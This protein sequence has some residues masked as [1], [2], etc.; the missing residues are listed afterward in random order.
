[1]K[2][3]VF[4]LAV[5][6]A[7]GFLVFH[8]NDPAVSETARPVQTAKPAE[9][10]DPVFEVK[11][12]AKAAV[13]DI[14]KLVA[15]E[16]KKIDAESAAAAPVPEPATESQPVVRDVAERPVHRTPHFDP[17]K[18]KANRTATFQPVKAKPAAV[19]GDAGE[20]VKFMT[21]KQRRRELNRL[22]RDMELMFAD[23]LTK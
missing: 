14:K 15:A 17:A 23:K 19:G 21:S 11:Q 8:N 22:A 1:M 4:N 18:D 5:I 12:A 9:A 7:I 13:I 16:M 6:G 20:E 3:L 10:M 2:F